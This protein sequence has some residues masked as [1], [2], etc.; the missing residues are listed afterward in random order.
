[1]KHLL[2]IFALSLCSLCSASTVK[3]ETVA[4]ASG[5]IDHRN[6]GQ[7]K[8][9]NWSRDTSSITF[10]L[11]DSVIC[12][13]NTK[14]HIIEAPKKWHVLKDR[15]YV[16]FQCADEFLAKTNIRIVEFDDKNRHFSIKVLGEQEGKMYRCRYIA[17]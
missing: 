1:M 16:E 13:N 12:I 6:N 17:D 5:V 10:E 14:F 9:T 2:F 3:F 8:W 4:N 11:S 7:Y 15:K